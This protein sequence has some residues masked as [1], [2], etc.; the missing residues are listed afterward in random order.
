[1]ASSDSLFSGFSIPLGRPDEKIS[2]AGLFIKKLRE[3]QVQELPKC[4]APILV[5][6]QVVM[7]ALESTKQGIAGG[8]AHRS[9]FGA[10]QVLQ[11]FIWRREIR[12]FGEDRIACSL[13]VLAHAERE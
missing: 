13:A 1:Y 4:I 5:S 9:S 12:K 7:T 8:D 11:G 10:F 2:G 3:D 6:I